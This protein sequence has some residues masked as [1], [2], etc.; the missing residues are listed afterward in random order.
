MGPLLALVLATF[1][2]FV[3][4]APESIAR[5]QNPPAVELV[6][7]TSRPAADSLGTASPD[8]LF[9]SRP[10]SLAVAGPDSLAGTVADSLGAAAFDSLR[11][12]GAVDTTGA[13]DEDEVFVLLE[14]EAR[15]RA[16]QPPTIGARTLDWRRAETVAGVVEALASTSVRV[17]GDKGMDSYLGLSPVGTRAPEIWS[18]GI[19]TRSPG[20]LDPGVWDRSSIGVDGVASSVDAH[21]PQAGEPEIR[22]LR[23][24]PREGRTLMVT[25]FSSTA[26]ETFQRA[27]SVT[28][29][30]TNRVLRLDFEDWSTD[31][32]YDYSLSP[33][34]AASPSRGRAAMRRFRIGS[35]FQIDDARVRF[36]FGRGRRFHRGDVVGTESFER[37]TGEVGIVVDHFGPR[38]VNTVSAWHLDFHD[39]E[40]AFA[41]DV[42]AARQGLRWQRRPDGA[43]WGFDA[44]AERWSMQ[45]ATADTLVRV[46]PSRVVRGALFVQ[47]DRDARIWPWLRAEVVD[48]EHTSRELG[49]G[50]RAGLR[51]RFGT[52]S[53][54]TFAAR[55]LRLPTLLESDGW[56]RIRTLTPLGADVSFTPRSFVWRGERRLDVEAVERAGVQFDGSPWG[57]TV[58]AVGEQWRLRDGIGWTDAGDVAQVV[59]EREVDALQ[60]GGLVERTMRF[61]GDADWR[62]RTWA[63]GRYVVDEI[64]VDASRGVGWPRWQVRARIGLDRNFYSARNRLGVDVEVHGRGTARD[65][66]LGPLGAVE[67]PSSWDVGTR[68]WLRVR[69]AEMSINYDN[70]LDRR[71]VEVAGTIRRGRQLRWQLVWPFFN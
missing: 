6:D 30:A 7:G 18:D 63:Q 67:I 47:G 9:G 57:W 16:L 35:D 65:D 53:V 48:G 43:G 20:D 8:S 13:S 66:G 26:S 21:G 50:G 15:L 34:V 11:A 40:D 27:V 38:A 2:G 1:A 39:D 22:L 29:P 69:D 28:T 32:G 42:D 55:D 31:T 10:D 33:T 41:Q 44:R 14:R 70:V 4:G 71:I 5:A 52:W 51:L 62:L 12:E 24:A 3:A 60:L 61:G 46:D 56:R 36:T 25:R 17:A 49:L 54:T 23:R 59:G 19:P 58:R 45:T 37:W 64:D 68:V